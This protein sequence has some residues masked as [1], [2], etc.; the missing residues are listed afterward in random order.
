M[1]KFERLELKNTMIQN[2]MKE[3]S[4]YGNDGWELI[5]YNEKTPSKFG[6]DYIVITILKKF[7]P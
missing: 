5:Y 4:K 2:I 6:D 3:L 7:I 1:W